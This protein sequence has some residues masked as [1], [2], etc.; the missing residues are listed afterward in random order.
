MHARSGGTLEVMG[1]LLGK[2][3]VLKFRYHTI[4]FEV[5]VSL[6]LGKIRE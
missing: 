5:H 4:G 2:V 1:L 6:I 3:L